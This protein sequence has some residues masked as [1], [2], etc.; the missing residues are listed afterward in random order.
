MIESNAL[1]FKAWFKA[2]I[3]S[4]VP[5]LMDRPKWHASDQE[6]NAGDIVL[7]LK[8]EKE[9][10]QQYQYGRVNDIYRGKDGLI[11]KVDVQYKNPTE[12][13]FRTTSRGVRDLVLISP[14]DELD[15]YEVLD[16]LVN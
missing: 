13:T 8:N 12:D 16:H 14:I 11:R 2:W 15:I 9:F 3:V 1:I 4:Y 7:F 10:D 5:T 6:I